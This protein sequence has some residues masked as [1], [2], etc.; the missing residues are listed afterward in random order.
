LGSMLSPVV[1]DA[2]LLNQAIETLRAYSLIRR[3]PRRKILSIHRLVQAVLGDAM[4]TATYQ[5]WAE[6]VVAAVDAALPEVEHST[7]ERYE[8]CL[9]HAQGCVQYIDRFQLTSPTVRRLLYQTG[10]Y[11]SVHACYKE[12]KL[13]FRRTQHIQEYKLGI[14]HPDLVA[15]LS[16][17]ANLY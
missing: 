5:Q 9:A 6:R 7:R 15:T 3:D 1:A 17:L 13:F 16:G 11:L 14:G 4:D 8:R 10:V 2:F 12:A